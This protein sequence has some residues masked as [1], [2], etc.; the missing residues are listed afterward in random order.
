MDHDDQVGSSRS[1]IMIQDDQI[2]NYSGLGD[3]DWAIMN[4][5]TLKIVI[6]KVFIENEF[7]FLEIEF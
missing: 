6:S 1:W 2:S 4:F 3:D 5:I 7:F